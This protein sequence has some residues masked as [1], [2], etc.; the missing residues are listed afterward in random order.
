MLFTLLH[1][2]EETEAEMRTVTQS[3]RA[4]SFFGKSDGERSAV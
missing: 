3:E 4:G 2:N 1:W